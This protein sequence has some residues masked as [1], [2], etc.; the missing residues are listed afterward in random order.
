MFVNHILKIESWNTEFAKHKFFFRFWVKI[1]GFPH[2][3]S[4][5]QAF[6]RSGKVN[7]KI[8]G[9]PGRVGT[10][11]TM[12][13]TCFIRGNMVHPDNATYFPYK[14][15]Y[16]ISSQHT[17]PICGNATYFPYK[18]QYGISRQHYILYNKSRPQT[19]TQ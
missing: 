7:D 16:S 6:S 18:W 1:P 17:S 3:L 5:F 14:W 9:F 13:H 19:I 15:Q 4:K 11:Y 2:F 8:P 12:E 10:L